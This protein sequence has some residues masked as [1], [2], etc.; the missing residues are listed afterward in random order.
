[1]SDK[2]SYSDAMPSSLMQKV[3]TGNANKGM[4]SASMPSAPAPAPSSPAPAPSAP[5]APTKNG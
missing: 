5:P 4:P 2:K 3:V 1:M